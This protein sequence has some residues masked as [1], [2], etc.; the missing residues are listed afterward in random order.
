MVYV[1]LNKNKRNLSPSAT[2]WLI[3]VPSMLIVTVLPFQGLNTLFCFHLGTFL[4]STKFTGR[5]SS[6][7][8][9][10]NV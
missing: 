5:T 4:E 2:M 1:E 8:K 3:D 7:H 9:Y 6:S 10:G